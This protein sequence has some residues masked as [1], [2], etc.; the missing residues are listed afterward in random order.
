MT[1]VSLEAGKKFIAKNEGKHKILIIEN[2][3]KSNCMIRSSNSE[4][5]FKGYKLMQYSD[6]DFSVEMGERLEITSD[7]DTTIRITGTNY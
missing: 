5:D 7:T 2:L 6:K 1:I 4:K 3:G